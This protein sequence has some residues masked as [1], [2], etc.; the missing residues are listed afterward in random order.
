MLVC[1][2]P[3]MKHSI[4]FSFKNVNRISIDIISMNEITSRRVYELAI[5]I[6]NLKSNHHR[7]GIWVVPDRCELLIIIDN[8]DYSGRVT[9]QLSHRLAATALIE[10]GAITV[11]YCCQKWRR[12][13]V[14]VTWLSQFL[15]PC[16]KSYQMVLVVSPLILGDPWMPTM[17]LV[18]A[19][20]I[21]P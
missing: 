13:H 9:S 19:A 8:Q 16:L 11:T 21:V 15:F 4:S 1:M 6:S 20:L 12:W 10:M 17:V 7:T 3:F 14:S 2:V 5:K 18:C